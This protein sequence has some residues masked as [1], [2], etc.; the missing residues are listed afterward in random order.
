MLSES[1]AP[2]VRSFGPTVV[3]AAVLVSARAGA[4]GAFPAAGQL[5][6]D[7]SD[8][9]HI[10]VRTTFGMVVSRD[11]GATWGWV[12]ESSAGYVDGEPGIAVTG[13][14]AILA[15]VTDGLSLATA[16]ACD[17]SFAPGI[18]P[19]VRD[20]SV[21]RDDP[22]KAVAVTSDAVADVTRLWE[23]WN[24]GATW[25]QA[26]RSEEHTSELQSPCNLVCR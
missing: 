2:E 11:G 5:V 21:H 10:V 26:G 3:L 17:W 9:Q 16:D 18:D 13:N 24:H 8:P 23:S 22:A 6:V 14:G 20:V 4:N 25:S 12:C 7:P 15:G 1:Y 19:K